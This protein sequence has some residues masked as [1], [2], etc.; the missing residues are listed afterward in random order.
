MVSTRRGGRGEGEASKAEEEEGGGKRGE[1]EESRAKRIKENMERMKSLGIADLS[2]QLKRQPA[3]SPSLRK[4]K[5]PPASS[6]DPPRRSSRF[7]PQ[8]F[9][10]SCLH[11][12]HSVPCL[13]RF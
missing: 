7:A 11:I 4:T 10:V 6:N 9:Q 8:F 5:P 12:S 2:K 13:I 3:S 1:Y